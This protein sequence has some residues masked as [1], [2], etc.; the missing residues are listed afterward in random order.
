MLF[1]SKEKLSRIF[2]NYLFITLVDYL[3]I[4]LN[5]KKKLTFFFEKALYNIIFTVWQYKNAILQ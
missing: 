1:Y 2:F 3:F 5:L 4:I